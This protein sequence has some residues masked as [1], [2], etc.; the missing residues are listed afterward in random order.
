MYVATKKTVDSSAAS[1][2]IAGFS[3]LTKEN[4]KIVQSFFFVNFEDHLCSHERNLQ[5][6]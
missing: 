2:P 1:F 6:E 5:A 3:Q 4:P